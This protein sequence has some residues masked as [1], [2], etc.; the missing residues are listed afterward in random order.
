MFRFNH[1]PDNSQR[2]QFAFM[3][4]RSANYFMDNNALVIKN[5]RFYNPDLSEIKLPAD[6]CGNPAGCLFEC[7][8]SNGTLII[9]DNLKVLSERG[10][11]LFELNPSASVSIVDSRDAIHK[12]GWTY[13]TVKGQIEGQPVSG[14]GQIPLVYEKAVQRPA[15]LKMTIGDQIKIIDTPNGASIHNPTPK[16]R[17]F[18]ACSF[19]SGLSRPWEGLHSIDSIRRDARR[20]GFPYAI[21][22]IDKNSAEI[23]IIKNGAKLLFTIDLERDFVTRIVMDGTFHGEMEFAYIEDDSVNFQPPE[24]EITGPLED[25]DGF[26]LM[27]L[28]EGDWLSASKGRRQ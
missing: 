9:L 5:H 18:T 27:K 2:S 17:M 20:F 15:W 16:D 23:V 4:N 12:R 14:Q 6:L 25:M 7:R 1:G 13:F 28:V 8:Q 22:R 10:A 21:R 26:W 24:G 11:G 19:L 3:E